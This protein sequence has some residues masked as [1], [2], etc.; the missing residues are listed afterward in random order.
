M[1]IIYFLLIKKHVTM[2]K[3]FISLA[4][5]CMQVVIALPLFSQQDCAN[6]DVISSLPYSATGLTTTGTISDYDDYD[7]CGSASMVNEDYVFSFT[8][9]ED[10][11]INVALLNTSIVTSGFI[12]VAN[13]GLF[14][15]DLC[16]DDPSVN[17]VAY[18]DDA[19]SNPSLNNINLTSGTTY[20]IIVS[21]ANTFLGDAT[22]V[23]FDIEI[24]KNVAD[25]IAV[26]SIENLVSACNLTQANIGCYITNNGTNPAAFFNVS[27]TING[28]TPVVQGFPTTLAPMTS[29]YFEFSTPADFP[30]VG[31]YQ[32][33]VSVSLTGD[34]EPAN[35]SYTL[36]LMRYPVYNSFPFTQDF[37]SGNGFFATGG[38]ASSWE[39]GN[40]D[41]TLSELVINTAASGDYCWV[42]NLEGNSNTGETSYLETPCFDL[43]SLF[44][45]V[46]DLNAWVE[47]YIGNSAR[48]L[49]STDGGT[50]WE[51]TVYNFAT[52]GGWENIVVQMPELTG[53]TNVKFRINYTGGL[54]VAN[55]IAIDDFTIKE[56][57]LNDIAVIDITDPQS[58]CGLGSNETVSIEIHNFGA[59]VQSNIPV[60]YS[61][62]G[63]LTWLSS[64]E[65]VSAT[66]QPG[67]GVVY[68]FMTHCDLSAYGDYEIVAKTINP[69]DEDNTNDEYSKTIVSQNTI[70]ADGYD[71][72]FES[73]PAGWYAYGENST[74]ELAMPAN[75]LINS[76]ADGSYAWVT[77]ATGYNNPSEISYLESPCFD[78]TEMVNPKIKAMVQYETSLIPML[79]NFYVEYS[80]DGMTWDTVTAGLAST[81]WYGTGLISFG[82][83]SGSSEGWIQ[84]AT[85]VPM[86][87]GQSSVKFRFVFDN[88]LFS[89]TDTEG[90]AVDKFE[91]SDCNLLPN[92]EFSYA[93]NGLEVSFINE[94]ENAETYDW[95][96]GDNDYFPSTSTEENPSFTYLAEGTYYVVL[97]VTNEC[98]SSEYGTYID[99][100]TASEILN[101][102]NISIYPNPATSLININ[103]VNAERFEIINANGQVISDFN[104]PSDVVTI[105]IRNL[106]AGNY[107]IKIISAEGNT[108]VPFVKE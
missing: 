2:K 24:T 90:V 72:S 108:V 76:A 37:E 82:T 84:V 99:V 50:T 51:D 103:G 104:A 68:T 39:Y 40:P 34:E 25:D 32:I 106:S 16:P 31:E 22:N 3:T 55:G 45:P 5:L 49:A 86:L 33:E 1:Q 81:G 65:T 80:I 30:T 67:E 83:W 60:D 66:L 87:A 93:I 61:I 28:G 98:S 21:S 6:A 41:E 15:T 23:N 79:S 42:T 95:N 18:V 35:D 85:D 53:E 9:A 48:I 43:S 78:F 94:S 62:D 19:I 17:C 14:I 36:S 57:V 8:P 69:G 92:A 10:M 77:N 105:D 74:M 4:A 70:S 91:I 46:L 20:Y 58:G 7:A 63:G 44:L 75:S 12:P 59:Q 97:T 47:L 52:T 54:L 88:S 64:P 100:I 56:T 13:I 102:E 26:T 101:A 89:M 71:E 29:E 96:F 107:F 73:G 27:Y 11:Q 38:T